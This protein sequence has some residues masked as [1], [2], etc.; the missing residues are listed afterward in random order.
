[1]TE[2]CDS[3]TVHPHLDDTE[4][5]V[6]L[7]LLASHKASLATERTAF[8]PE[9]IPS[10]DCD[11]LVVVPGQDDGRLLPTLKRLDQLLH[12]VAVCIGRSIVS[13]EEL[14]HHTRSDLNIGFHLTEEL[15]ILASL[16]EL[17]TG[18]QSCVAFLLEPQIV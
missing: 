4:A 11:L 14:H 1:V 6:S 13:V 15:D 2:A 3:V 8:E 10:E 5:L 7:D 16:L 18:N 12:L 9:D 17:C